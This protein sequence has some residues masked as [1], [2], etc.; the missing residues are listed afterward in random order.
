M[1]VQA[2]YRASLPSGTSFVDLVS[3]AVIE[4]DQ[5]DVAF[6]T[7]ADFAAAGVPVLPPARLTGAGSCQSTVPGPSG[8]VKPGSARSGPGLSLPRRSGR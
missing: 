5:L 6:A 4:R 2:R 8:A 1:I 3:F 7:D